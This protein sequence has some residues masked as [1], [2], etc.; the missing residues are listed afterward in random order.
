MVPYLDLIFISY[1]HSRSLWLVGW[2]RSTLMSEC[3]SWDQHNHHSTIL[4]IPLPYL[5][6]SNWSGHWL[7]RA[8]INWLGH[9]VL[10]VFESFFCRPLTNQPI[11]FLLPLNV[12]IYVFIL[13]T[14]LFTQYRSSGLPTKSL[15]NVRISRHCCLSSYL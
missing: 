13:T 1:N 2:T 15:P 10:T 6:S 4:A 12:F 8:N 9:S 5:S 14:Y 7:R 3:P 11:H